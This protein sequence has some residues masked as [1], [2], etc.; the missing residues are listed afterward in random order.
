MLSDDEA[1][2]YYGQG[3]AHGID[4]GLQI[5]MMR[6]IGQGRV[7]EILNPADESLKIDMFFRRVSWARGAE[8]ALEQLGERERE[9]LQ[10]YCDGLNA[11]FSRRLPW[12]L[13]K[14]C[15]HRPEPWKP[16]DTILLVRM[17]GYVSLASS[18]GEIER[19]FIE[20]VQAGVSEEKLHDL[21]PG[22]LGGLDIELIRK[23]KLGESMV[24]TELWGSAM[25]RMM[26]SNNWVVS[27]RKTVSGKPILAND[28]HLEGNRLP[29]VWCEMCLQSGDRYVMGGTLPGIP[30]VVAGRNNDVA[31]AVT[32][33]FMDSEDSWI[34]QCRDGNYLREDGEDSDWVPFQKRT[35]EIKRKRGDN[36]EVDFYEND[37]GVLDGD[38]N[39]E[40]HYLATRWAPAESGSG[41]LRAC[42]GFFQAST[43]GEVTALY[44]GIE[45]AWNCIAADQNGDVEYQM[46]GCAP[47]RRKGV[48][49]FVPLAGWKKE[50]DWQGFLRPDELPRM[51]NPPEGFFATANENLNAYGEGNPIDVA[52]GSYR[53][54]RIA[55]LLAARDDFRVEDMRAMHD[56][57]YSLQAELFMAILR[58]LLPDS[59]AA[60]I[61]KNWDYCYDAESQGAYQF[62]RFYQELYREVFGKNGLGEKV[63]EWIWDT[64]GSF[65]DFYDNFDGV[66]LAESSV[67]FG[68][69]SREEIYLAALEIALGEAPKRWGSVRQFTMSHMFFGGRLPKWLGFDRG[70]YTLKGGRATIHQGQ[71]YSNAGRVTSFMPSFRLISDLANEGVISNVAGGPSDRRFSKWYRS[72]V[73]N[74]LSGKYKRTLPERPGGGT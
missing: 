64:T 20:M 16:E 38:P 43:A 29:A 55:D 25:P 4:R 36:V 19:M 66:L 31:W 57:V 60:E 46:T 11:A 13:T 6:I 15:R 18:Q 71:I 39:T 56:D 8:A 40:G 52:M 28:V 22:I 61:L 63:V 73:K 26:A 1:G 9:L 7:S 24:P 47:R 51:K 5:L 44:A 35:E 21:F 10:A 72:D 49:G 41:A 23:V 14:I 68:D 65:T 3:F 33:A 58:P 45:S 48:S 30:G 27:G 69:R 12:E 62:E 17:M 2:L 74:W 59:D 32:Y 42:L 50:N 67:W 54:D 70:P 34:E 53:A 37:H